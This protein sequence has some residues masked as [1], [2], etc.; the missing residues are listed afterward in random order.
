MDDEIKLNIQ[1]QAGI[2]SVF[3]RLN[4][5]PWY[6]IGE[7]VDNSTASYFSHKS[8]MNFY[9]FKKIYVKITYDSALNKLTIT[10]DAFGMELADFQRAIKLDSK[11][12]NDKGRN[13]FGMG[14]KT[15]ASWFGNT[16]SV[17]STQL[18]SINKYYAKIDIMKLK[19]DNLN[20]IDIKRSDVDKMSHGTTIEITDVTK[21]INAPTTQSKIKTL[22]SSMYRRDIKNG[23]INIYFNDELLKYAELPILKFR[24]TEWTKDVDFEFSFNGKNFHVTGFVAI[25]GKGSFPKAGFSLFRYNRVVIGGLDQNY[26]PHEIFGQAQSQISLKL[27]GEFNMED[28]PVNQAKDGFVWDDGLEEEF[29]KYLRQNILDYITIANISSIK[30]VEEEEFDKKASTSVENEVKKSFEG[31]VLDSEDEESNFIENTCTNKEVTRFIDEVNYDNHQ[32]DVFLENS[33]RSYTV[34]LNMVEKKIF[35]VY[36]K[37]AENDNWFEYSPESSEIIIN[38]NHPFF[39]PYT[40]QEDFKIILD[41]FVVAFVSSEELAK[42]SSSSNG[43]PIGY[44]LPSSI[45][46]NMNKIL[47]KLS[48]QLGEKK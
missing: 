13:E 30:R 21:K 2:L 48:N 14:L 27:F 9:R 24:N 12:V 16:W 1:P 4:Y 45:R 17:T 47:K 34:Q 6:A 33:C 8:T 25:M 5:R 18:G 43:T 7:F 11:P 10:D 28:F 19:L 38:I 22:L 15:A 35:T 41:K 29:I 40:K 36:W 39:K 3:S 26:K 31:I 20:S 23:N 32:N 44:I 46:N 37:I 42:I